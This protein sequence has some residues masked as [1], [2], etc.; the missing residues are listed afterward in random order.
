MEG[1]PKPWITFFHSHVRGHRQRLDFHSRWPPQKTSHIFSSEPERS[2]SIARYYSAPS[3]TLVPMET[4]VSARAA[5]MLL[6]KPRSVGCSNRAPGIMSTPSVSLI[7]NKTFNILRESPP[8]SKKSL[9]G[10]MSVSANS[11]AHMRDTSLSVA[12]KSLSVLC[13]I[14]APPSKMDIWRRMA[15]QYVRARAASGMDG[16]RQIDFSAS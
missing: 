4:N 2:G 14:N 6:Q 5:S 9:S 13:D 11:L 1:F 10:Q 8:N 12:V 7:R 15:N 3:T 16:R